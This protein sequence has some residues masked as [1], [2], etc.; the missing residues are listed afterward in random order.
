MRVCQCCGAT[1]EWRHA[2]PSAVRSGRGKYCSKS[3]QAQISG[4]KHGRSFGPN[5]I[6]PQKLDRTYQ[7]WQSMIQRCTNP[8]STSWPKYGALGVAVC[9]RWRDDF[10][11]FLA[12]MGDR[13][14]GMSLD[15][16]DCRGNYEPE[17]CRWATAHEQ[18][19]NR[20]DA[21][22]L[23]VGGERIAASELERRHNFPR[24]TIANRIRHGMALEQILKPMRYRKYPA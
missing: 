13:P 22:W 1:F 11:N 8:N 7:S 16:I 23:T 2:S 15:R 10:R 3:C 6:G 9:D 12:D 17:N 21:I 14:A 5:R 18:A 20:P 24:G 19:Q 4:R